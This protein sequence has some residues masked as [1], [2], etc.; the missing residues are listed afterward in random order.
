MDWNQARMDVL[1]WITGFVERPHP[2]LSN[3]SPCP[4]A[5][6]ARLDGRLDL[7]AGTTPWRDLFQAD[8][9]DHDVVM[10]I[11][12]PSKISADELERAVSRLNQEHLTPRD[13]IALSDHPQSPEQVRGVTMNQG[14]WALVFLQQ[15]SKLNAHAVQI[16]RSGYYD[17]WSESY[18]QDLFQHRRDPRQ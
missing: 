9:G 1:N 11:Y 2:L 17:G 8:L 4:F 5:R 16:A 14:Q 12:D 18:L 13:L 6:R 3:W 7:R 10:W 15:L